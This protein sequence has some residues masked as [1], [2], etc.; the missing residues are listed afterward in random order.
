MVLYYV[1]ALFL[2]LF[3]CSPIRKAWQPDVRGKCIITQ[4]SILLADV[5]ISIITDLTIF[6]IPIPLVW[7]LQITLKRKLRIFIVFAGGLG[8]VSH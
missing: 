2:K 3:R 4:Y 5:I 6:L 7:N 8:Y 1:P